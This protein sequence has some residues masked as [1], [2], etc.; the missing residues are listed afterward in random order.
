[1]DD[2]TFTLVTTTILLFTSFIFMIGNVIYLYY[3]DLK[4]L[5]K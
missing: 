2:T 3:E 5:L 4:R 1:M